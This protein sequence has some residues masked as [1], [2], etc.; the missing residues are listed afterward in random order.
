M[1]FQNS[2]N[3]ARAP[4]PRAAFSVAHFPWDAVPVGKSFAL[5]KS[6]VESDANLRV[7]SHQY[8]KRN[9]KKF[10]VIKHPGEYYEIA[11]VV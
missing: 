10:R 5:P 9:G 6:S 11:R 4:G 8:G 7:Y 2:S 3:I 1:E